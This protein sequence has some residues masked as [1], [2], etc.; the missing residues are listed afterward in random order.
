[1]AIRSRKSAFEVPVYRKII[2]EQVMQVV[3]EE[4]DIIVQLI[5][6]FL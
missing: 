2:P 4:I 5:E 1:M 3:E 6:E